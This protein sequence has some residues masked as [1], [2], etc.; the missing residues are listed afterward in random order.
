MIT[1]WFPWPDTPIRGIWV[2]DQARSIALDHDV[3][4]LAFRPKEGAV[5]P[6]ELTETTEHGIRTLRVAY[7]PPAFPGMGMRAARRGALAA[8]ELLEAGGFLPEVVHAHVFLASPAALPVAHRLGAPLVLQE[9]LSRITDGRLGLLER[10][11]ARLSY[12][13]A[14]VV[15]PAGGPLAAEVRRLGAR[16]VIEMP[17][18]LDTDR[19]H[20]RERSAEAST[21]GKAIAVGSLHPKK[22]HRH[23]LEAMPAVLDRRPDFRLELVGEGPMREELESATHRLGIAEAVRFHGFRSKQEVAGMMRTCDLHIL[24]S[25][26]ENLP[27]VVAEAMAS[28]IPTVGTSVG[29]VPEMLSGGGGVVVPRGDPAALA[30]AILEVCGGLRSYDPERLAASARESYGLAAVDSRWT[31]VY[32]SLLSGESPRRRGA[33]STV[34]QGVAATDGR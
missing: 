33:S 30:A 10:L 32:E 14:D 19:F 24:P 17:N 9:N 4:I 27:L 6:F 21:G 2:I 26:R 29:G 22:G 20:P 15:C 31:R 18:A 11:L 3:A 28:G 8:L 7:P 25:M 12:R 23:L 13:R 34:N 5:A 1:P 16:K